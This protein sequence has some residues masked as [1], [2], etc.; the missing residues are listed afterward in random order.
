MC[1][2]GALDPLSLYTGNRL[3]GN[4]SDAVSIEF[5]L[6]NATLR[7]H[8]NGLIALTGADCYATL[9]SAPMHA[10]RVILVQRGQVLTLRVVR[11]GIRAYLYMVGGTDVPETMGSRSTGLKAGFGGFE[12]RPLKDGDGL[13]VL[14][15][16]T[17]YAPD[18]NGDTVAVR[19]VC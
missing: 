1:T 11:G 10:W 15:A 17:A 5:T 9:D 16:N 3:V 7:F 18:I 8:T 4:R 13:P 14:P 2:P 12:G 19:V 6:G